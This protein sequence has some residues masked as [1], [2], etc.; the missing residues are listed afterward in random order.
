MPSTPALQHSSI[1]HLRL[2]ATSADKSFRLSD[3][4]RRPMRVVE[5]RARYVRLERLTYLGNR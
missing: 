1:C 4:T 5:S 2:S 3:S